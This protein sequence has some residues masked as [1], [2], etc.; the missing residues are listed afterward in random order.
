MSLNAMVLLYRLSFT[1]QTPSLYIVW[2][3]IPEL[4]SNIKK[5]I[6]YYIDITSI[7]E[8]EKFIKNDDTAFID[9]ELRDLKD[10][11]DDIVVDDYVEFTCTEVQE[12]IMI[13]YKVDIK[14]F[15]S[16]RIN[17]KIIEYNQK[18]LAKSEKSKPYNPIVISDEGLELI[19]FLSLDCTSADGEWHSDSEIKIDKLGYIC[20]NG[21]KT[22]DFW[23]GSI[24]S[25]KIPLRIK[26]RNICGDETVWKI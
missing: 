3:G 15:L 24:K 11:L 23:D 13:E 5:V 26:I 7:P 12:L 14:K 16:D 25:E 19:E 8:I 10:V 21:K 2:Y 4:D 9:I 17:Q 18:E 20:V 6:V 22:K 1:R